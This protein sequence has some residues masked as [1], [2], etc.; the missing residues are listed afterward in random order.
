MKLT[1]KR[2]LYEIKK[3]P[4]NYLLISDLATSLNN[5]G[6]KREALKYV[7]L[8]LKLNPSIHDLK[9]KFIILRN[10]KKYKKGNDV[11]NSILRIE[12]LNFFCLHCKLWLPNKVVNSNEKL[13]I[14]KKII[15]IKVKLKC[16]PF[17]IIDEIFNK[18]NKKSKKIALDF[19]TELYKYDKSFAFFLIYVE[20]YLFNKNPSIKLFKEVPLKK[21]S[22][23]HKSIFFKILSKVEEE[24]GDLLKAEKYCKKSC[25]FYPCKCGCNYSILA[26]ILMK[27]KKYMSAAKYYKL[28]L[29]SKDNKGDKKLATI[30]YYNEALFYSKKYSLASKG[31]LYLS[32]LRGTKIKKNIKKESLFYLKAIEKKLIPNYKSTRLTKKISKELNNLGLC[33]I[34]KKLDAVHKDIKINQNLLKSFEKSL[35]NI[36]KQSPDKIYVII[37]NLSKSDTINK[38]QRTSLKE[39]MEKYR[40]ISDFA[41]KTE[42]WLKISKYLLKSFP[43]LIKF[44][45]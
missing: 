5:S 26:G 8:A 11:L 34:Y 27:R 31:F 37:K 10:L 17:H 3:N 1:Q 38:E 16:I 15:R 36:A 39:I 12:P 33:H 41:Q 30:F 29:N 21:L 25:E 28:A 22:L 18:F 9:N 32:S 24:K 6:D 7:N 42:F 2:L 14:F 44:L 19:A 23:E 45:L 43:I 4:K 40:K 13:K 35:N 20:Y